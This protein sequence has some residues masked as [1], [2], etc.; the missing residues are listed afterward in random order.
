MPCGGPQSA[1]ACG[2]LPPTLP[3]SQSFH[4]WLRTRGDPEAAVRISCLVSLSD[5]E[6]SE[7]AP[8]TITCTWSGMLETPITNCHLQPKVNDEQTAMTNSYNTDNGIQGTQSDIK[9][10][11]KCPHRHTH[12]HH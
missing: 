11:G 9:D 2:T 3:S 10:K 6:T 8:S 5:E 1:Q 4:G 12:T 7:E